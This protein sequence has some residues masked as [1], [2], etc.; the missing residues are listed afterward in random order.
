MRGSKW[1]YNI[2]IDRREIGCE[3]VNWINMTNLKI[4]YWDFVNTVMN[5]RVPYNKIDWPDK[6][7][8]AFTGRSCKI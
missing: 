2:K 7:L 5:L 4:H 3:G 8:A 6:Q 1:K